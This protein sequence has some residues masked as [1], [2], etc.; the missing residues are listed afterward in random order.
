LRM[1]DGDAEE[2]PSVA[3]NGRLGERLHQFLVH[4]RRMSS[5]PAA[6]PFVQQSKMLESP[7][8]C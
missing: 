8:R 3:R 1:N 6:P 5:T 4:D 7:V 2:D